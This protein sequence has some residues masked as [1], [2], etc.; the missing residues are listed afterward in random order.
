MS[1]NSIIAGLDIGTTRISQVIARVN[2]EGEIDIIGV[3]EEPCQGL[4]RGVIVDIDEVASAIATANKRATRMAGVNTRSVFVGVP[5]IRVSCAASHGM[6]A[7]SGDDWRITALDVKQ[8]LDAASVLAVPPDREIISVLPQ[9][10]IVD[11]LGGIQDPEGMTG[12]RLEVNARVIT[13]QVTILENMAESVERAGLSIEGRILEPVAVAQAILT[14]EQTHRGAMLVDIGGQITQVVAFY[15]GTPI[16]FLCVPV[17]GVHITNDIAIGM[18]IPFEEAERIKQRSASGG[19]NDKDKD[20]FIQDIIDARLREIIELIE[21]ETREVRNTGLVPCGV[22]FAGAGSFAPGTLELASEILD[23]PAQIGK[24]HP[25][26]VPKGIEPRSLSQVAL[27]ITRHV[28]GDSRFLL[29]RESQPSAFKRALFNLRGW[30]DE[31][32]KDFF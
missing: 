29:A 2:D 7:T 32:L 27:G 22:F 18:K 8:A 13:G 26:S 3:G 19:E 11:G 24:S 4:R 30:F 6:T 28:A 23:L 25:I 5:V 16:Q 10:Y 31:F 1:H 17:G 15:E 9:E 12:I 14:D 20:E 21:S